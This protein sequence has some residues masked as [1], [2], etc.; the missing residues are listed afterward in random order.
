VYL[1]FN[2]DDNHPKYEVYAATSIHK[3]VSFDL[4]TSRVIVILH[5]KHQVM[6]L[7]PQSDFGTYSQSQFE[8]SSF[9][10]S[11]S[12]LSQGMNAELGLNVLPR[13]LSVRPLSASVSQLDDFITSQGSIIMAFISTIAA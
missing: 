9:P 3:G 13:P 4:A 6:H 1:I 5:R 11:Q 2:T 8:V 10:H 7:Q 12:Q